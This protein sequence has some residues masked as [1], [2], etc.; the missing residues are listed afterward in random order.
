ML[1]TQRTDVF[2]PVP[3][4]QTILHRIEP[5]NV[6]SYVPQLLPRCM[7]ITQQENA[8]KTVQE[9]TLILTQMIQ[10]DFASES[11]REV[12]TWRIQQ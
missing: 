6:Y 3:P 5:G 8:Y 9:E 12:L 11:A 2:Q 4:N 7:L 1:I 10:Q